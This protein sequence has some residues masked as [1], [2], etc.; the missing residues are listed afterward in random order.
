MKQEVD[1]ELCVA[2][3]S[4]KS[5]AVPFFDHV[6]GKIL[7]RGGKIVN[8]DGVVDADVLIDA[9]DG[10]ILAVGN[11]IDAPGDCKVRRSMQ[12]FEKY[13]RSVANLIN[14]LRS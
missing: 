14:N 12:H 5:A 10:K 2:A 3:D 6:S 13:F 11:D 1:E 7:I 4:R 8:D 9:A